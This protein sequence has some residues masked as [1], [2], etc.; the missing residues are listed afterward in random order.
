MRAG[1][2]RRDFLPPAGK[3]STSRAAPP[4]ITPRMP[5]TFRYGDTIPVLVYIG[6]NSEEGA[7]MKHCLAVFLLLVVCGTNGYAA[8]HRHHAH[9]RNHHHSRRHHHA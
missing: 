4:R 7:L 2:L 6:K 3:V 9:H 1:A 5:P 8:I